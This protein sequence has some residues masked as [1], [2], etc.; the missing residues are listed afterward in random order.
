M[1]NFERHLEVAAIVGGAVSTALLRAG[2]VSPGGAAVLWAASCVG[3]VLPDI[4]LG[5]SL[6][7][8]NIFVGLGVIAA[9]AVATGWSG[10]NIFE[11]WA[12]CVVAYLGVR[13]VLKSGLNRVVEHRGV[14]HSVL[15]GVL[16]WFI[17]TSVLSLIDFGSIYA[18][19]TGSFVFLGFLLHLILDEVYSVDIVGFRVK[20]SF[21]SALKLVDRRER[22][23]SVMMAAATIV[24][25]FLA[26][27]PGPFVSFIVDY[28]TYYAIWEGFM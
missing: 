25:F 10:P 8:K 16:M 12:A 26:P 28:H 14:V 21:G 3:G 27:W 7:T 2:I 19:V 1:A 24:F 4:D 11:I 9:L 5:T 23:V 22:W 20:K 6:A 17:V 15:C 13:Y 18:W